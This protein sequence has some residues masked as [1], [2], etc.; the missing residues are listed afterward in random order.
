MT[1]QAARIAALFDAL[2]DSYD[3]VGVDFFQPIA[4]GLVTA[5]GPK[6]GEDWLDIGC[7]RGAVLL[8]VAKAIGDNGMA[9]GT[10]ISPRM[11]EE[12]RGLVAENG[13]SNVEVQISDAQSPSL[14]GRSFDAI[15]ACLVLFFLPD[16]AAALSSWLPLLRQGGRLGVTTFG[17]MDPRWESVDS[18]FEPY[19]PPAMKD[20]RTS[21]KVGPFAS[22]S[23]ME[24]LLSNAGFVD[25]RTEVVSIPV[26]FAS[27][28]QWE[29]FTWSTGQR[30]MWLAI[31]EEQRPGVRAEAERLL[32]K[33][34]EPDGSI[35]FSQEIRHTL[36]FRP[37][38]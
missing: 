7:G 15:A 3:A 19:L 33:F 17:A 31:P 12:T 18:V 23:G 13:L 5:M 29:A 2:A 11:V 37:V 24:A 30:G 25:V 16:P 14:T 34:A 10:D 1:E 26:H 32:A 35:L 6:K 27:T 21:G 22:D 38:G 8:P 4:S 9:L 28:D 36:G 20:A